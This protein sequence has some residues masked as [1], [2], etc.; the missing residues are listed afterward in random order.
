[1]KNSYIV[2]GLLIALFA[3]VPV[4]S[5][6]TAVMLSI[7]LGTGLAVLGIL[8]LLKAGQVS[9]G[10]GLYFAASAYTIAFLVKSGARLDGLTLLLIGALASFVLAMLVGAFVVRYRTIFFSM[11][12]L[13]ISM[14]AYSLLDKLYAITGGS[15]GLNIP[16]TS[17]GGVVLD[18]TQYELSLFYV[19][20]FLAVVCGYAVHRYLQSPLGKAL[21]A[22]KSNETRLEYLGVSSKSVL[23]VA[24]ALSAL[25]TG[26]G[27]GLFALISGHVTPELGYWV[28]SGE[29]V[30]ICVL[31]GMGSVTGPF[32]GAVT[33]ELVRNY[34]A[35][36]ASDYWQAILG[37]CLLLV[38]MFAPRGLAGLREIN[39]RRF[40]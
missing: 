14:V 16:R 22:I 27:G 23:H 24:Y 3:L 20:L 39:W 11:F 10:H 40:A 34:A 7:G 29:F 37:V 5:P 4:L 18:R 13:A 30:F 19:A 21:D 9:F 26:V 25:L 6:W 12:N 2:G 36:I 1:M 15:D 33:F 28:R 8:I 31:G 32:L 17:L 35:A 38:V